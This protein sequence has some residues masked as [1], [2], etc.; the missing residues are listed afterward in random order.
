[1]FARKTLISKA[2]ESSRKIFPLKTINDTKTLTSS[3]VYSTAGTKRPKNSE[4]NFGPIMRIRSQ[5]ANETSKPINP[6]RG[7]IGMKSNVSGKFQ[8]NFCRNLL[9]DSI[10]KIRKI[11]SFD[12]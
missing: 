5:S 4:E 11:A 12:W 3:F 8:P 10:V 1:L 2:V 7:T 9:L 6:R